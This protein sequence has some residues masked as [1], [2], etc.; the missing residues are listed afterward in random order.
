MSFQH[1]TKFKGKKNAKL[2]KELGISFPDSYVRRF[3]GE[4]NIKTLSVYT[5]IRQSY[6][7]VLVLVNPFESYCMGRIA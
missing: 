3:Y 1:F 5:Q 7:A 2:E 4:N 6:I